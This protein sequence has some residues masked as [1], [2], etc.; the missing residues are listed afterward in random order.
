MAFF[1]D[2]QVKNQNFTGYPQNKPHLIVPFKLVG[3]VEA[4]SQVVEDDDAALGD[5]VAVITPALTKR[6]E[7]CCAYYSYVSLHLRGG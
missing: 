5:Q 4:S 3:I 6:L 7:S 1:T 2:A